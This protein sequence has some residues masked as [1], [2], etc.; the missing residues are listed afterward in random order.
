LKLKYHE[1]FREDIL[2]RGER[3]YLI[4]AILFQKSKVEGNNDEKIVIELISQDFMILGD[5]TR[6]E[7]T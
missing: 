4:L 3:W 6:P 7:I 5:T 1:F 2:V